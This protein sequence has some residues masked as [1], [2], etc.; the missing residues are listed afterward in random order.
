MYQLYGRF[1]II[2]LITV[3]KSNDHNESVDNVF[4]VVVVK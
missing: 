4:I 1:N 3:S 2:S